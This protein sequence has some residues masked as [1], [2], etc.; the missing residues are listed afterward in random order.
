[1]KR[2]RVQARRGIARIDILNIASTPSQ[3]ADSLSD[4]YRVRRFTWHLSV[5]SRPTEA[6][7]K[8]KE[9]YDHEL[10]V[11]SYV[12]TGTISLS[13]RPE[14]FEA[15][16][17]LLKTIRSKMRLRRYRAG[18]ALQPPRPCIAP[19]DCSL[20]ERCSVDSCSAQSS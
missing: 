20:T 16:E 13:L 18:D 10:Q 2:C 8:L 4:S 14:V 7:G 1:M 3:P 11:Q 19:T 15:W 17:H 5:P 12:A 9:I 6:E